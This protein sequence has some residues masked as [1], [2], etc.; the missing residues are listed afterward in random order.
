M[1]GGVL[2]YTHYGADVG[3][4][5]VRRCLSIASALQERGIESVFLLDALCEAVP[6]EVKKFE[7]HYFSEF[8]TYDPLKNR[9]TN[10]Y[11]IISQCIKNYNLRVVFFD[12]YSVSDSLLQDLKKDLVIMASFDDF[13]MTNPNYNL[14]VDHNSPRAIRNDGGIVLGGFEHCV[15]GDQYRKLKR[16]K[17]QINSRGHK[18]GKLNL[19]VS[20]GSGPVLAYEEMIMSSFIDIKINS[21]YNI[22]WLSSNK[23]PKNDSSDAIEI[24]KMEAIDNMASFLVDMDVSIGSCGVNSLERCCMGIPSLVFKTAD[25]QQRNYQGLIDRGIAIPIN[26]VRDISERLTY[27]FQNPQSLREQSIRCALSVDGKGASRVAFGIH[28]LLNSLLS[29]HETQREGT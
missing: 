26:N 12:S 8:S 11:E 14:I 5:H 29:M 16:T 20:L 3:Y 10:V 1:S 7:Y 6:P 23:L 18:N 17:N 21:M 24:N 9:T 15:L 4:G 27:L 28:S 13:G 19:F 2:F 22:Y 25:N